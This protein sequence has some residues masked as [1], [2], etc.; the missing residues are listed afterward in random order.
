MLLLPLAAPPPGYSC[1]YLLHQFYNGY[2]LRFELFI[3]CVLEI[4][5]GY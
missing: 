1:K 5:I 3:S 4:Y 2:D